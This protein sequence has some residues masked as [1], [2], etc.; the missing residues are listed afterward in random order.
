MAKGRKTGG[1]Q[2]GTPNKN[3]SERR[4][5]IDALKL[6]GAD[7]FMFFC[8]LLASEDAPFKERSRAAELLL[9]YCRPKRSAVEHHSTGRTHEDRLALME[10]EKLEW[11]KSALADEP[12]EPQKAVS[13]NHPGSERPN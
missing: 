8:Q 12:P 13:L 11:L 6:S 10:A 2:K 3:T 1:R 7:P 4:A 9:P 5:A